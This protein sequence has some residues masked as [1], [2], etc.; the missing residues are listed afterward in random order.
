M[1]TLHN[2]HFPN[3]SSAY[4]TAR[5]KLLEAEIALRRQTEEVAQLRRRLPIGGKM[6]ENYLFSEKGRK[7]TKFSDLF[8]KGKN[9]LVVYSM[10]FDPTWEEPCPM[11]NSIVDGL[12]GNA[13]QIYQ[14][15][16]LAVVGKAPIEKLLEYAK[17]TG[18]NHVRIVSS[19][20]NTYNK[21]YFGEKNGEQVPM[22]NVFIKKKDGIYHTW[23]SE[24]TFAPADPGQN[25]RLADII[26]P[27]WNVL[28]LTPEGRG[29]DWYP[30]VTY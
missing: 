17:K 22:I 18:W 26:W 5:N 10:M 23:G 12:N 19:F 24:M 13:R 29:K 15:I 28:D 21:D 27:L 4:R 9:T 1:K 16:N 20:E 3:E 14:K 8:Q 11:C 2:K 25:E 7:K 30:E 6:K